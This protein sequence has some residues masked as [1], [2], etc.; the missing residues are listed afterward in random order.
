MTDPIRQA[1]AGALL[2]RPAR[3]GFN[4][5]TAASNRF[6][7]TAS[8]AEDG[9][10]RARLEF[11]ALRSGLCGAG[12]RVCAVDDTPEP[13]KPDAVFPNNW[14]SFHRDG[15]AFLYPMQA[16]N[17]RS[18]R[19]LEVL[20]AVERDLGWRRRRLID[21]GSLEHSGRHLEGTGSL[22]LDHVHRVAYACRSARTDAD[23]VRDWSQL[24]GYEAVVFDAHGSDGIALYHTNVMLSIGTRWV[25]VCADSI[26]AADRERVLRSLRRSGRSVFEIGMELMLAF[27]ANVLELRGQ[28]HVETLQHVLVVSL[29]AC[30]AWQQHA[31]PDWERLR[32]CVDRIVEVAV[33]TIE[34]LGGGSVRCMIAEVPDSDP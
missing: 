5:Q 10:R 22:V 30:R 11:E 25:V 31:R 4:T 17:R 19:R 32:A 2:L 8:D 1:A 15:T 20:S 24:M 27:G 7:R 34:R 3:F 13:P 14:V 6:Q 21:W 28:S 26:A 12:V 18:E 9:G 23:L 33:P 29:Q 16:A